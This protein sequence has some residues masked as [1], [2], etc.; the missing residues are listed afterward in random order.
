MKEEWKEEYERYREN[1]KHFML[2]VFAKDKTIA[3]T[4]SEFED[5]FFAFKRGEKHQ[6]FDYLYQVY[7]N[8]WTTAFEHLPKGMAKS[9]EE[10]K[11]AQNISDT[12]EFCLMPLLCQC[13]S[14]NYSGM[15]YMDDYQHSAACV[16]ISG[17][18]YEEHSELYN[19]MTHCEPCY[20]RE[21]GDDE[22]NGGIALEA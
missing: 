17:T 15:Y 22:G 3:L 1:L 18:P 9:N 12:L 19:K 8:L 16:V 20:N 21:Y 5:L 2:A 13:C 10:R 11:E 4:D 7:Q 14:S 6:N